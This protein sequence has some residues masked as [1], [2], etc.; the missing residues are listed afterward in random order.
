[1]EARISGSEAVVRGKENVEKVHSENYYGSKES[2]EKL[3]LS[4]CEVF[5][6]AFNKGNISIKHQDEK[7]SKDQ[8]MRLMSERDSE[9]STKYP[10]Y[11]DLRERGLT[12]KTGFKY[13]THFRTYKRGVN[14]YKEGPKTNREHTD[15]LVHCKNEASNLSLTDL[16]QRVRLGENV[17]ANTVMAVVDSEKDITYYDIQR[18]KP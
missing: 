18:I 3:S 13:G 7:L 8:A 10:V 11:S 5:H 12:V 4:F 14:P 9:F 16:S 17:R 15:R 6:L 1:M 2:D